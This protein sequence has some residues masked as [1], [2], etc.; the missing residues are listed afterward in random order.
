M[1]NLDMMIAAHAL[2]IPAVL[3]SSDHVF[4][5]V[6]QLKTQDWAKA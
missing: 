3:V 2:D 4:R 5:R 1:G 6:K